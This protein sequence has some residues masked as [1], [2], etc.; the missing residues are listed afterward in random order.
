MLDSANLSSMFAPASAGDLEALADLRVA[1]MC[2]SLG[3][4]GRFDPE[5]A[6]ARLHQTFQPAHT[7]R[8]L[9]EGR[10][11]GFYA[12]APADSGRH[13]KHLYIHPDFQGRG[14]GTSAL[15]RLLADTDARGLAVTVG[16]LKESPSNR[17][18]ARHGFLPTHESEWDIHY[19]RPAAAAP[20][21]IHYSEERLLPLDELVALYRAHAWSAADK[22][23]L[24]HQALLHS[25]TLVS[26]WEK[27]RLVG[28][29][30]AISD[31]FLVVYYPHL[32][33]SPDRQGQGIGTGIIRRLRERYAGF[34]M[35]MLVADGRTCDFYRKLGFSR[36]GQTEPMWIYSV[37]DH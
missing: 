23:A 33:V 15:R 10:L 13:L 9:L 3:R 1:A 11:I 14:F 16:A 29:G 24:L 12:T 17:F 4:V 22:P 36:A 31:G 30:N 19:L 25:H 8:L 35:H 7:W 18:Y 5:R 6:R 2:E 37:S 27:G 26:A 34:H 28:V 20:D 21:G 32:L